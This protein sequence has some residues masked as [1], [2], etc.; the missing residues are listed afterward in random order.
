MVISLVT[1]RKKRVF[2][3]I[4]D[5]LIQLTLRKHQ[6]N[7]QESHQNPNK[8]AVHHNPI[9]LIRAKPAPILAV[10]NQVKHPLKI[11]EDKETIQTLK[12][13]NKQAFT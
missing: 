1:W 4:K 5:H 7:H 6:L 2:L 12:N 10:E 3:V 13:D 9:N 8:K 11:L